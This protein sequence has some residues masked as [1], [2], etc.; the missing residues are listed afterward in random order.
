MIG[1]VGIGQSISPE[2]SAQAMRVG[3]RMLGKWSIQRLLLYTI[4]TRPFALT[5][6]NQDYTVGPSV[7]A[8]FNQPRPVFVESATAIIP[9]STEERGMNI[10][11]P[12]KWRAIPDKL[13]QCSINGAPTDIWPEYTYPTLAF[14][15]FPVPQNPASAIKLGTWEVLQ[16]F[17]TIFDILN[18][19]FGYEEA[20]VLNLAFELTPFYDM[21]PSV[22]VAQ[23]GADALN[24]IKALNAQGL[25]GAIQDRLLQLPNLDVP[26]PT[27][28]APQA[29]GGQ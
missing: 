27:G 2:M 18:F 9:G 14:H 24:S 1:Q 8:T 7:G 13:A 19:P 11:T 6:G 20:F 22:N 16:Q 23:L 29:G 25:Q 26:I 5:P 3:N 15:V 12:P 21:P 17:L 28:P 10:L 4:N